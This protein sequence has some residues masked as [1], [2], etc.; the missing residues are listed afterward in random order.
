MMHVLT[1]KYYAYKNN[2]FLCIKLIH[3]SIKN[4]FFYRSLT[5]IL[6]KILFVLF[7]LKHKI[8]RLNI[9]SYFNV[10]KD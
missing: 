10:I 7:N 6:N 9:K 1:N 5:K 2:T 8:Y 3:K 4:P